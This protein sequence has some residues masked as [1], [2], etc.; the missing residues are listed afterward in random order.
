MD[1]TYSSYKQKAEAQI[2]LFQAKVND[3]K[4]RAKDA[5]ADA[6]IALDDK[7]R[8]LEDSLADGRRQLNEYRDDRQDGWEAFRD[9]IDGIM[10]GIR[11]K[12]E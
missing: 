2:E 12:L 10:D 5:T 9:K 1:D 11:E 6:R 7:I 8:E 4:A 3:L